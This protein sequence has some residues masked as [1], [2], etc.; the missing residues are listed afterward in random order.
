VSKSRYLDW[1]TGLGSQCALEDTPPRR[2]PLLSLSGV[3]LQFYRQIGK[4][5]LGHPQISSNCE[6]TLIAIFRSNADNHPSN[7]RVQAAAQELR[8]ALVPTPSAKVPV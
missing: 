7:I 8:S 3:F 2:G 4:S 1:L 5:S 6:A